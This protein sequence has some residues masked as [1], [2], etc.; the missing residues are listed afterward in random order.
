ML[1]DRVSKKVGLVLGGGGA[2]GLAHIGVLKVLIREG[3][4]IDLIAGASM[5]GIIGAA[6]AAGFTIEQIEA[7]ALRIISRRHRARLIDLK[8]SGGGLVKGTRIYRYL[9]SLVGEERT[10]AD[11]HIPLALVAVDVVTGHEVILREGRL[12]DALRATMSVPG[13]FEPVKLGERYLVDGGILNNLPVD[14]A[15]LMGAHAV[16]AVDVLPAYLEDMPGEPPVPRLFKA[17]LLPH[18]LQD[19][20]HIQMI[21][22]ARLTAFRQECSPADVIIRP[23]LPDDISLLA[24][25][26]KAAIAIAAGETAAEAA[27][28]QIRALTSA[29]PS[30]A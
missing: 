9:G 2:R 26:S 14:V 3:I 16:I 1:P 17:P 7:E 10:F 22:V 24:G 30:E 8:L 4:P 13:I 15:R 5:G 27:M 19:L 6:I 25:F 18:A 21:M 12:V 23:Q 28:P 29:A 20:L 11:L